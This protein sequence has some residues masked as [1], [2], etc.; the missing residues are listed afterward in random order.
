MNRII[1]TDY[2]G[3]V[4]IHT[5]LFQADTVFKVLKN[6]KAYLKTLPLGEIKGVVSD[7]ATLVNPETI[8]LGEGSVIEP[9]A[10]V[11]GPCFIGKHTEIRHGAYL[12]G[13][14]LIGDHCVVGHTTEV[15]HSI[16]LDHAKAG[17][18]A[19]IGD[20]ILG[21]EVNL[22]AGT[23]C[24]N[25]KLTQTEVSIMLDGKKYLTGLKKL[26]AIIGDYTQIGCNSVTNPGTLL[27]KRTLCYPLTN[28]S[29][30]ILENSCVKPIQKNKVVQKKR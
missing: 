12:R 10:Y 24:A 13:E 9:G 7:Q 19:Y 23:K 11:K 5:N 16:F 3:S 18:F 4:G 20:S 14:V 15:K 25:L 29:G 28:V 17:H 1:V 26:G 6:L 21:Y 30:I 2:F 8:F 27:G 22:G